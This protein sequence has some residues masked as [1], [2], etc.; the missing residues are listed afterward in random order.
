MSLPEQLLEQARHLAT[1][2]R[3]KPRQASLRRAISTAYYA[4][5][6]FLIAEG[7]L[8]WK[9][10]EQRPLLARL[11]EHGKMKAASEK[12]RGECDRL[13]NARPISL[14]KAH[15]DATRGLR[16]VAETF[17]RM[18]QNRHSAD[19]DNSK[20]WARLE[21]IDLIARTESALRSWHNIREEP[22]AQSYLIS[23]LGSPKG[24]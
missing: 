12:Q 6:H 16:E 13:L 21:V 7:T 2:E 5:F 15:L 18:Q 17:V 22:Q 11:F 19:Y 3:K 24:A 20:G 9:R 10:V 14:S 8:N 23:L 1:R 4:L